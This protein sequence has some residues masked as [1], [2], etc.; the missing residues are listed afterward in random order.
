[1]TA[2]MYSGPPIYTS[3]RR[4]KRHLTLR[5]LLSSILFIVAFVAVAS[6]GLS[7]VVGWSLTHPARQPVVATPN[8]F[9]L[10]YSDISFA[11][12]QGGL[13]LQG[14][15]IPA[16]LTKR[17]VIEAHGYK[18]NRAN[19]A[20]A[21]PT[22]KA[23]H[24]AG[25]AVLMFDFRDSGNSAGKRVT[26]GLYELQDLLGAVDYAKSLGYQHI[27]V[28]GFSMGAATA[29]E[30]ATKDN[31]IQATVADSPFANLNTYLSTN[32]SV[33][34]H[35]PNWPFTPEIL[36][37][38]RVISGLNARQVDPLHD[39]ETWQ[40]KPLLLIAGTAD[41]TIPDSNSILL[42]DNMVKTGSTDALWIVPGAKHV[43]AWKVAPK[44]YEDRVIRFFAQY[45]R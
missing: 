12:R 22:A 1:M 11:S 45:L 30:A 24:D 17:I 4:R 3:R 13:K 14:W 19:D 36:W 26:V 7:Y 25:I 35:L 40:P 27:G 8:A 34:T 20:P 16:G 5:Q 31:A 28:I 2:R 39:L 21:L 6:F 38:M 43:G 18:G 41:H 42:Y 44:A 10:P 23:L 9:S 29:I 15:L 37:E 33:W 32:M